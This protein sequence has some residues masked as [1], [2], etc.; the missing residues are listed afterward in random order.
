M[1]GSE[2][3]KYVTA[4]VVHYWESPR[5]PEIRRERRRKREPWMTRWF[6]QLLPIGLRIWWNRRKR[7]S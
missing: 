7:Y 6:G 1:D 4:R 2:Y 3:F 5:G